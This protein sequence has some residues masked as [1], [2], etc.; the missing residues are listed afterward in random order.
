M[1]ISLTYLKS[2]QQS[3][4]SLLITI[5]STG[6]SIMKRSMLVT[7]FVALGVSLS[8]IGCQ[9]EGASLTSPD[10]SSGYTPR[11]VELPKS[12]ALQKTLMATANISAVNG[13]VLGINAADADDAASIS[14]DLS[15]TFAPGA[16]SSDIVAS[17]STDSKCMM[18]WFE[19][20]G[21]TFN[22]PA[23]FVAKIKGVDLSWVS[24]GQVLS[25]WYQGPGGWTKM[26]GTVTYNKA[27]GYVECLNG[28]LPHFSRYGFGI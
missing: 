13:G 9:N 27:T 4:D 1:Q 21:T 26:N 8:L 20:H 25:L 19:P 5:L 24:N 10:G 18:Y 7:L 28:E 23:K 17:V 16:V 3:I 15:L 11:F 2:N 12:A 22:A 14:Y 6:G